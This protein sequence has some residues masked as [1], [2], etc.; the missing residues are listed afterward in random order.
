MRKNIKGWPFGVVS[1]YGRRFD[2]ENSLLRIIEFQRLDLKS[3]GKRWRRK[4][5]QNGSKQALRR[6]NQKF[7]VLK[8]AKELSST[9]ISC[10]MLYYTTSS[11]IPQLS[12]KVCNKQSRVHNGAWGINER[13]G[14]WHS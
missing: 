11:V 2:N 1:S 3:S 13:R 10:P 14:Q 5:E 8:M 9:S 6:K 12:L 4:S 7:L